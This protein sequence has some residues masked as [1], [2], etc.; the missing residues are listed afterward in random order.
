MTHFS[1]G[2]SCTCGACTRWRLAAL[3]PNPTQITE[4]VWGPPL[5]ADSC[6][7]AKTQAAYEAWLSGASRYG[8]ES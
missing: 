4:T 7:V 1:P 3:V 8:G 5:P 6:T 2:Q